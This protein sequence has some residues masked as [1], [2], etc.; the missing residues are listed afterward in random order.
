MKS[1]RAVS[2]QTRNL[3]KYT[4]SFYCYTHC[5]CC[6][7]WLS[8]VA[9]SGPPQNISTEATSSQTVYLTWNPPL[10]EEQ[11]GV[12][13]GYFIK[14]TLLERGET[15][16]VFSEMSELIVESLKPYTTYGFVIRAQTCIGIGPF[17]TLPVVATTFED[18]KNTE[19]H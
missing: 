19:K 17:S 15:F 4:H 18:G 10:P 3:Q 5:S 8:S 16:Q 7:A 9:P 2:L 6:V 11:N 14:V 12:I 13:T 1:S